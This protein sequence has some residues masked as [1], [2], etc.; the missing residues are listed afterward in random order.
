[1]M[2]EKK[3]YGFVIDLERC[4]DCRACLVACRAENNV[5]I[6]NTRIWV[7]DLGVQGEFPILSR[8]FIP[9]NCM[10]CEEPPCVEV[11]TAGATYKDSQTGLV[12]IDHEACI[13]CGYCIEACPYDARY[14][15]NERGVADK[16]SACSHRLDVGLQPACVATCLGGSRIFGD[17]NDPKSD[18]S[19]ALR[20]AKNVQRPVTAE[21]DT[22]PNLFYINGDGLDEKV[23]PRAP[24]Y[25]TA[26]KFFNKVAVP[27]VIG[28]VGLAFL[29]QA[30]AFA[31]QLIS[32]EEDFE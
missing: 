2:A 31:K 28:G 15:D 27:A 11:C 3:R 10:H 30:A 16:C 20:E 26:E 6:P 4:I 14:R 1:M 22:G 13:G 7:H 24:R 23:L 29:G 25:L 8:T 32:G 5:S 21:V 12:H 19:I 9:D 17:L 18:V